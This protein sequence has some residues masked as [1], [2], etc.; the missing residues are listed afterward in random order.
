MSNEKTH[1]DESKTWAR[2]IFAVTLFVEDLDEAKA[3]YQ[4]GDCQVGLGNC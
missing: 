4:M 3:F 2:R 1:K